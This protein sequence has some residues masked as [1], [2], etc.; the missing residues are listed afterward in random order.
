MSSA[1]IALTFQ[2]SASHLA[3]L[4]RRVIHS[5]RC[6]P[7]R[8]T[9]GAFDEVSGMF[10]FRRLPIGDHGGWQWSEFSLAYHYARWR[11]IAES[12]YI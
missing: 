1:K 2:R 9:A 11:A 6:G 10:A 12:K 8:S 4:R 3:G 7:V 5:E